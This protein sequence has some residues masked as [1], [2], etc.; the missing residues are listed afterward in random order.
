L[1]LKYTGGAAKNA[2]GALKSAGQ[3]PNLLVELE[4]S[5]W[6]CGQ[7]ISDLSRDI[8]TLARRFPRR[9]GDLPDGQEIS[10]RT[11]RF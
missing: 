8:L 5:W 9:P 6:K 3:S 11:G 2:V 7:E 1:A 4:I 10:S